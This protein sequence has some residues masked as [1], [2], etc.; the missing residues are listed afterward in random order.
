VLV[1]KK[2]RIGGVRL[3]WRIDGSLVVRT[4]PTSA[5]APTRYNPLGWFIATITRVVDGRSALRGRDEAP[6]IVVT[7]AGAEAVMYGSTLLSIRQGAYYSVTALTVW[8]LCC[9][10]TT[11]LCFKLAKKA[12]WSQRWWQMTDY[13]APFGDELGAMGAILLQSRQLDPDRRSKLLHELTGWLPA[14]TITKRPIHELTHQPLA[15][16]LMRYKH[17]WCAVRRTKPLPTWALEMAVD[18]WDPD[19][20]D[21]MSNLAVTFDAATHLSRTSS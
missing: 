11:M 21:A 19:A 17:V 16:R 18:L 7:L 3:Y 4:Y 10:L 12:T 13:V 14:V 15:Q 1:I 2:L 6:G 9:M 20:L 8:L 5:D